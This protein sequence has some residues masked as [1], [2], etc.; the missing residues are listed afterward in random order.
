[1]MRQKRRAIT[2][3]EYKR[4]SGKIAEVVL[5]DPELGQSDFVMS[6]ISAFK[7]PDTLPIIETLFKMGKRVAVPVSDTAART[8]TVCEIFNTNDLKK[9]AYNI[10]EPTH[11][12][13]IDFNKID[14]VLVPGLAFDRHGFR[15]GFG[16]GYYDKL[17]SEGTAHKIG[18]CYDFQLFDDIPKDDHDIKMDKIITERE[19]IYAV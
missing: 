17:L 9:G 6:Y 18:I 11:I 4:L 13:E 3:E 10:L 7:E 16:M 12:N 1:M 15:M 2:T 8:I 14:L 19:I 5:N